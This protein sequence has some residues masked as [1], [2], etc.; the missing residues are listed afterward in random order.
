MEQLKVGFAEVQITPPLGINVTGYYQT[1]IADGVLDDLYMQAAV[2]SL[3]GKLSALVTVDL[4]GV[5]RPAI[6]DILAYAEEVTGIPKNSVFL[7]CSHTHT[8]PRV[9]YNSP[10]PLGAKY[11]D[12]Y[13][14]KVSDALKMA[15]DDLK[16]AKIGYGAGQAPR[17]SFVRRFRMKDGKVRTN[18]G[19]NNPDILHPI[20]DVEE[21]VGVIRIDREGA[22]G[23]VVAHFGVHAD[24]VGGCKIS[25]D[26][27]GFLRAAV[28]N[29]IGNVHCMFVN[30][31]EGD[32]NH[33]NV[34]P[35]PGE[36]NGM[37]HDF[38]DVDRGYPHSR[39]MGNVIAGGVLQVYEKVKYV[40]IDAIG[41]ADKLVKVPANLPAPEE[42]PLAHKYDEL[43]RAGKDHEIPFKGMELTTELARAQRMVKLENGPDFFDVPVTAMRLGPIALV[44]FGGEPFFEIGKGVKDN[45]N[46]EMVLPCALT[47]GNEGYFPTTNAYTEGGYESASSQFKCGVAELLIDE[48]NKLIESLK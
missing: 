48:A 31:P 47:N 37:F 8:G 42:L 19:V 34:F 10:E 32:L 13:K 15:L 11:Y 9:L 41:A 29:A 27:P 38:D 7:A 39:H 40:D 12:F 3:G 6:D 43:H 2:F 35:R 45:E 26:F 30:G 1:R 16:P 18:P 24:V 20:G 23:I 4:I 14:H 33:V 25:A 28:R 17:I 5:H 21:R 22:D 36:G 44:G 46:Y